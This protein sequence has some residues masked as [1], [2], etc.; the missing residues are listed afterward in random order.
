MAS[1]KLTRAR[2]EN[3][4]LTACDDLRGNMEPL[5]QKQVSGGAA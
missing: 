5:M 4:L 2:L 3:L 1:A